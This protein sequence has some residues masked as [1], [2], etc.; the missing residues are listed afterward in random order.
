MQNLRIPGELAALQIFHKRL[1]PRLLCFAQGALVF[2]LD[3]YQS[4]NLRRHFAQRRSEP[5]DVR[6]KGEDP[7]LQLVQHT[8]RREQR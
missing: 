6:F 2:Q 4:A 7:L 1:N 8:L 5:G 3:Q